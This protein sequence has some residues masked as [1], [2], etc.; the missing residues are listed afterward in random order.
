MGSRQAGARPGHRAMLSAQGHHAKIC[1][2]SAGGR[3]M[4]TTMAERVCFYQPM[5]AFVSR[6][7]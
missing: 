6:N 5:G 3:R 7:N 4:I 1:N 2:V